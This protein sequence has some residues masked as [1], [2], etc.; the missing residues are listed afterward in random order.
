MAAGTM[1]E[2]APAWAV[3]NYLPVVEVARYISIQAGV[4]VRSSSRPI[5]ASATPGQF[6][7]AAS[8]PRIR[9]FPAARRPPSVPRRADCSAEPLGE[10]PWGPLGAPSEVTQEKARPLALPRA[11]SS[12]A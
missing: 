5:A 12:A 1:A 7:K 4:R 2:K 9:E 3:V 10:Q 11:R 6:S 8:I